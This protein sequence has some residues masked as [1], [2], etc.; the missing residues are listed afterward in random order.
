MVPARRLAL[1][2]TT[3]DAGD[4]VPR[5]DGTIGLPLNPRPSILPLETAP[6]LGIPPREV[7]DD[8]G[9][10]L[11]PPRPRHA[12]APLLSR[13][14]L[15]TATSPDVVR[16]A[17]RHVGGVPVRTVARPAPSALGVVVPT[18][19]PVS[20]AMADGVLVGDS[21]VVADAVAPRHSR[22]IH[23]AEV[24]AALRLTE[25]PFHTPRTGE[26][27]RAAK[28]VTRPPLAPLPS[29]PPD[30]VMPAEEPRLA[31][32]LTRFREVGHQGGLP[33][34]AVRPDAPPLL[35]TPLGPRRFQILVDTRDLPLIG[36]DLIE[37]SRDDPRGVGADDG[38]TTR[39]AAPALGAAPRP[40][41]SVLTEAGVTTT[42]LRPTPV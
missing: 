6:P 13:P 1:P 24:T 33:S 3:E 29:A 30:A 5:L 39:L 16:E 11:A 18:D 21:A 41:P 8:A 37:G 32:G 7:R 2:L 38:R 10:R 36:A 12:G 15:E 14:L 26:A 17:A 35:P 34:E 31:T 23:A 19:A 40:P 25:T 28:T 9:D 42:G 20:E 27:P 22:R 4:S